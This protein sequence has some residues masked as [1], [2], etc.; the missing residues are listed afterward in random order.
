MQVWDF[1][2]VYE[3]TVYSSINRWLTNALRFM[4]GG[5]GM[6][7]ATSSYDGTVKVVWRGSGGRAGWVC[8]PAVAAAA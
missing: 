5:D 2:K 7:C 3:R 6:R 8:G 1:V 4:P